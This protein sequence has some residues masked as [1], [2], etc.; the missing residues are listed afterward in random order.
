M[1]KNRKHVSE[2]SEYLVMS[3][4][5]FVLDEY[6]T[7]FFTSPSLTVTNGGKYGIGISFNYN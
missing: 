4:K 7:L 3:Q 5:V 2:T 6:L 1:S